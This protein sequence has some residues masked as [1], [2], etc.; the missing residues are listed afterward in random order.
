VAR[1]S[2][3]SRAKKRAPVQSLGG[4]I[5][6]PF[7]RYCARGEGTLRG[8]AER[9]ERLRLSQRL[10]RWMIY[11]LKTLTFA[12]FSTM[13]S[14]PTLSIAFT[15]MAFLTGAL[16]FSSAADCS[17]DSLL[18]SS[19]AKAG[20]TTSARAAK[21]GKTFFNSE[22]LSGWLRGPG[23]RALRVGWRRVA[24]A[25][26]QISPHGS[27]ILLASA[28][29]WRRLWPVRAPGVSTPARIKRRR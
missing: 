22:L 29:M 20:V 17:V 11:F 16:S 6:A 18:F 8:K 26:M 4:G 15:P 24:G 19:P 2:R 5:P 28:P 23:G 27:I 7:D 10:W 14:F 3:K 1:H 9:S 13:P 12:P 25:K 21:S